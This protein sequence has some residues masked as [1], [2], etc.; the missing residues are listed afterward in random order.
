MLVAEARLCGNWHK[1]QQTCPTQGV[2]CHKCGKRNH[3]ARVCRSKVKK[4]ATLNLHSIEQEQE[5]SDE[6]EHLFVAT[7]HTTSG[8]IE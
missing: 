2:E 5:S 4:A 3:S 1:K 7:L 8:S 6:G